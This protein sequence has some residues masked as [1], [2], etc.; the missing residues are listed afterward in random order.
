MWA[1]GTG[2]VYNW[3]FK[4]KASGYTAAYSKVLARL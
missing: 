2:K 3:N 4:T 1:E